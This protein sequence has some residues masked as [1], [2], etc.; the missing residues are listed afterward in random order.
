MS[1]VIELVNNDGTSIDKMPKNPLEEKWAKKYNLNGFGV[2]CSNVLGKSEN[3]NPIM[4]F[5]CVICHSRGCW[6]SDSFVVPE[7]DK[8]EYEKYL[9]ELNE[10]HKKILNS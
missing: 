9:K 3:G 10:Y 1:Q 4:N 7:E 5:S 6:R 8:E 2:E